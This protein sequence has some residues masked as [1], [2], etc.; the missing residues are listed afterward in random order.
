[1]IPA[2]SN[3]ACPFSHYDGG[4]H[5]IVRQNRADPT[6]GESL[7]P[8]RAAPIDGTP[9][10]RRGIP[11]IMAIDEQHLLG[12]CEQASTEQD[13]KR[14]LELTQQI[15]SLLAELLDGKERVKPS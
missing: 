3:L 4:H 11:V 13:S 8:P 6:F 5:E 2:F 10:I 14:L 1:M 9:K 12:L 15:D 7:I